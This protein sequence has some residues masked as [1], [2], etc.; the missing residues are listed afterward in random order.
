MV[1]SSNFPCSKSLMLGS[2][3]ADTS[4]LTVDNVVYFLNDFFP[5]EKHLKIPEHQSV[6]AP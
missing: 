5:L 3:M 6:T 1:F 4:C 2:V